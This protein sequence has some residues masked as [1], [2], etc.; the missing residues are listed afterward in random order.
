MLK[1]TIIAALAVMAPV[2]AHADET[3]GL[4]IEARV[5]YETPTVSGDGDIYKIGSAV[6]Y[7]GEVGFD[8]KLGK[9]SKLRFGPYATYEASSVSICDGGDCLSVES[10][11]GVGGRLGYAL[12]DSS[13]I[14]I[15]A[16]Y[17]EF[18]LKATSGT[19]SGTQTETGIQGALGYEAKVAKKI[20]WFAEVNYGD[21]GAL[22]GVPG[23]NLQ[24]RQVVT[25]VGVRF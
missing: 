4:R 14:Y 3:S 25:G 17:A 15:K 2:R 11:L 21:Y 12:S 18:K 22:D 7:G 5:G 24:R 16:G 23:V 6:S 10:N 1:K 9:N 20:F 19:F 13:V 8:L